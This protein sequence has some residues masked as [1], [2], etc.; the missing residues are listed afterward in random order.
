[1]LGGVVFITHS[2]DQYIKKRRNTE[3]REIKKRKRLTNKINGTI[4]HSNTRGELS[5]KI[6]IHVGRIK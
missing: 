4:K 1:M 6:E 3:R 5:S 2:C